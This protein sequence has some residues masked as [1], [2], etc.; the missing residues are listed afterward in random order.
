MQ[1]PRLLA[2]ALLLL[3]ASLAHAVPP[4]A[5][6]QVPGVYRMQL[7]EFQVTALSDGT[8]TI[9]LDELLTHTTPGHVHQVLA[10]DFLKPRAET[11]INAYLV[12]T[13]TSL[14]LI[15]TGAGGLFGPTGG[16]LVAS[17]KLAGYTPADIDTVLLTHIH[18]DHSGGLT[19][20]GKPVFPNA[21]VWVDRHEAAHWL[22]QSRHGAAVDHGGFDEAMASLKPYL[23]SGRVKTF[24]APAQ[25]V[26]GIRAEAARGH[27]PGHSLFVAESHR[28]RLVFWGD[29][30]HAANVQVAE[31]QI[32]IKFDLDSPAAARQRKVWFADAARRGDLVAAA[33]ISFPGIGRL[34][35][36][37][38]G[39]YRWVPLNY[40]TALKK[41]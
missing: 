30:L 17:L 39:G 11:S 20:D 41:P 25:V 40:S 12:H 33:H 32:T 6:S 7:G 37:P 21:T 18:R 15:D 27:T 3:A 29:L 8:V 22:D 24:D 19:V 1:S 34:Q 31:P 10:R 13:G 16:D 26:P 23:D 38:R 2:D 35:T 5:D 9:P 14:V 36:A 4:Q 28:Q